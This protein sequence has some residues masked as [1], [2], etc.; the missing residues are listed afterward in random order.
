MSK[1]VRRV[2]GQRHRELI[3]DVEQEIRLALWKRIQSGKN[4]DHPVSYLYKVALTTALALLRRQEPEETVAN[5][6]EAVPARGAPAHGALL[7]Q[8]RSLLVEQLLGSLPD[9]ESQALRAYLA[10]FNHVEVAQL[11]GWTNSVAR[12]RI[13]RALET[14][15]AG[16]QREKE[17]G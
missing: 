15:R 8:E 16:Q 17:R 11:F 3:P 4:L 5:P 10:G 7:P 2:C 14:L 9:E 1:A 13:Y 6:E 12:H